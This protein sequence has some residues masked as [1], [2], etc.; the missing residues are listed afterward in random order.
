MDESVYKVI[1]LVGTSTKSWEDVVNNVVVKA[2][3]SLR[4]YNTLLRIALK[5]PTYLLQRKICIRS[6]GINTVRK[7]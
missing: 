5:L 6:D 1:Y 4:I 7:R 2:S 3:E